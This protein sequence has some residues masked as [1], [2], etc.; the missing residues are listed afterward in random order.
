MSVR[1]IILVATMLSMPAWLLA[2]KD[3][4]MGTWK[5]IDIKPPQTYI[6]KIAP[7]PGGF[8][9]NRA[10]VDADGKEFQGG[11]TAKFGDQYTEVTGDPRVDEIRF[12]LV[13]R[14]TYETE[15]RKNGLPH[16]ISRWAVSH[17]GTILT[18]VRWAAPN[19]DR[20]P[21]DIG[22]QVYEKISDTATDVKRYQ[23]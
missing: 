4:M 21:D 2:Q 22:I 13:S 16:S 3:P 12:K 9:M 8:T 18:I 20:P 1:T 23:D 19:G 14:Y 17:D 7:A 11:Y 10:G 6:R 5:R 15:S